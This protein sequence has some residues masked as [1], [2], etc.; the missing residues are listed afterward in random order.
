M[1]VLDFQ[2]LSKDTFDLDRRIRFAAICGRT[3]EIK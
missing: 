2:K 1:T 3:G